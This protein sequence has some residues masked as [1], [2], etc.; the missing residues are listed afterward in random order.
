[1]TST[2]GIVVLLL[3]PFA[4]NDPRPCCCIK[5]PLIS[6][7][8]IDSTS[9]TTKFVPDFLFSLNVGFRSKSFFFSWITTLTS[10]GRVSSNFLALF[11]RFLL[12][13]YYSGAICIHSGTNNPRMRYKKS[14]TKLLTSGQL[15]PLI[16][17][18]LTHGSLLD[19]WSRR[20]QGIKAKR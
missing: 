6:L 17:H 15:S 10:F 14:K 16:A 7:H 8:F 9:L 4:W 19:P 5:M 1:M 3:C 2:G 11:P 13:Y 18:G 12:F 20:I